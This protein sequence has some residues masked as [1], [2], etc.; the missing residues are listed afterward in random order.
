MANLR[1]GN[2]ER[3]DSESEHIGPLDT[4]DNISAKR[5]AG[6]SWNASTL[7]WERQQTADSSEFGAYDID[8]GATSY[9]GFTKADGTWLVKKLTSTRLS[10]ATATNNGS[11]TT[12]SDAWSNRATL[13][14]GR[15]DEAF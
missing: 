2:I 10:Y 11:V 1:T 12:Y 7:S 9:F 14:Y 3:Q 5:I 6:Y 8:E 15:R 13:T 4:G